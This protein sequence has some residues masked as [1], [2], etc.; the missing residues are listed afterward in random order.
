[1]FSVF[2]FTFVLNSRISASSD[3]FF[4]SLAAALQ[5]FVIRAWG[6]REG[7]GAQGGPQLW[8]GQGWFG[9]PTAKSKSVLGPARRILGPSNLLAGGSQVTAT[10]RMQLD[11]L[12]ECRS[13]VLKE[14][15]LYFQCYG[16]QG[17]VGVMPTP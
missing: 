16:I 9:A 11:R 3:H 12:C 5:K 14:R 8:G 4:G 13:L 17:W 7:Q 6:G 10:R 2:L 1:M 15:T